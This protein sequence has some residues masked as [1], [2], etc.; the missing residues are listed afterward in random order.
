MEKLIKRKQESFDGICCI[1]KALALFFC[2]YPLF[3]VFFT[4]TP[5]E[6][7]SE[8]S[9]ESLGIS[10]GLL[11]LVLAIWLILQRK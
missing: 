11:L 6:S 7:L 3:G 1:L 10:L 4:Y 8:I 9:L 2:F 5:R